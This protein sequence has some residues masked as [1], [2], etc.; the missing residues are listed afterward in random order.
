[1]EQCTS[2]VILRAQ[3]QFEGSKSYFS[4][5]LSSDN[6]SCHTQTYR[7]NTHTQTNKQTNK[8]TKL[9]KHIRVLPVCIHHNPKYIT[10]S[11]TDDYNKIDAKS[12]YKQYTQYLI[13]NFKTSAH[14]TKNFKYTIQ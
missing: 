12:M 6:H 3:N 4:D 13:L 7:T 10:E 2:E 5:L 9:Q 8:Q 1:M 11:I 14:V